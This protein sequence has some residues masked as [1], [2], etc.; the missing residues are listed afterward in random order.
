MQ[1]RRASQ[2]GTLILVSVCQHLNYD[3]L[4]WFTI[5]PRMDGKRPEDVRLTCRK[6]RATFAPVPNLGGRG[7]AHGAPA[8]FR[9]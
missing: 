1:N 6:C 2:C 5:R 3:C 7:P 9:D 4:F 8:L